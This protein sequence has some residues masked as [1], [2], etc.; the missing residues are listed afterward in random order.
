[1]PSVASWLHRYQFLEKLLPRDRGPARL[2]RCFFGN[3]HSIIDPFDLH[4]EYRVVRNPCSHLG[5][6]KSVVTFVEHGSESLDQMLQVGVLRLGNQF[7]SPFHAPV[8]TPEVMVRRCFSHLC[9]MG[10]EFCPF[11]IW[12]HSVKG[13]IQMDQ[14]G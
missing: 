12:K 4:I 2:G 3:T 13:V 11:V 1:M 5:C 10:F 8:A 9:V 7:D 6:P 14:H